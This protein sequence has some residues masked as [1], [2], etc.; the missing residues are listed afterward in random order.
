MRVPAETREPPPHDLAPGDVEEG[1]Q[2]LGA[3]RVAVQEV[4]EPA[5]AVPAIRRC[6]QPGDRD[7]GRE[8][9]GGVLGEEAAGGDQAWVDV[10]H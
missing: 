6:P 10:H 5:D 9:L 4:P 7:V 3:A 8:Q 2:D 1:V